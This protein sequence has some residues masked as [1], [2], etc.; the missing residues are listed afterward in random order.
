MA[1]STILVRGEG[2]KFKAAIGLGGL[3]V[4]V[5]LAFLYRLE[6]GLIVLAIGSAVGARFWIWAIHQKNFADHLKRQAGLERRKLEAETKRLEYEADKARILRHFLEF[7][8]GVFHIEHPGEA[9]KVRQFYPAVQASKPL[10]DLPPLLPPPEPPIKRLL[11]IDWRH[12]LIL[13]PTGSGK[14]TIANHLIDAAEYNAIIY[15]LDPHAT[16]NRLRGLPWS[17]RA[18]VVG[19][20]RDWTAIDAM[21][22]SLLGEMNDRFK[23]S[24]AAMQPVY[25]A[26]DEWL[27][28][29]KNCPH[30][31]EFFETIGSEAAKVNM[32]LMIATQAATVDD[33]GCSAAVRDNLVELRLDH[34]LKAQNRGELRWGRRRDSV[35]VV[36]LPGPY[37]ALPVPLGYRAYFPPAV[38]Q[39][40]EVLEPMEPVPDLDAGPV[41]AVPTEKELRICELWDEGGWSQRAIYL[42][43]YGKEPGGGRQLNEGITEIL[44][45]FGRIE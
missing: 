31:R 38:Y 18:Q 45:R 19:D 21:L 22:I 24:G 3:A 27:A 10:A 2:W 33:L 37:K 20:G 29:L 5:V 13:G 4:I 41:P 42:E 34:A 39:R 35:E 8:S 40:A 17:P 36:E 23:L 16:Q 28:V 26:N 14:T 1:D 7:N 44:R 32:H 11:D 15:A 6:V 25:I 9:V 30:A 12:L 43:I